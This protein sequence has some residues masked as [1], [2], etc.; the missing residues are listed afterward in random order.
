MSTCVKTFR[1]CRLVRELNVTQVLRSSEFISFS[2]GFNRVIQVVFDVRTVST[3]Y[4]SLAEGKPLK[5][6]WVIR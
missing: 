4:D 2:P 1:M 6:F 3:V 5:R